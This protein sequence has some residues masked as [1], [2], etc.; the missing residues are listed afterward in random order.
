MVCR[1][2]QH[3][4]IHPIHLSP[5]CLVSAPRAVR[6]ARTKPDA[7]AQLGC[8][9]PKPANRVVGSTDTPRSASMHAFE[10]T[11]ADWDPRR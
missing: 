3:V 10:T 9:S 6:L 4:D 8:L 1:L 11:V 5:E 7:L 2:L